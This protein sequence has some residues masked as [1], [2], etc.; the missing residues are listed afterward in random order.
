VV[1]LVAVDHVLFTRF[2]LTSAPDN[3][4][5]IRLQIHDDSGVV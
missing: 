2:I 4:A 5:A 3:A 1:F